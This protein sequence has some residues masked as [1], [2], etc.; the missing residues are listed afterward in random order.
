MP[1]KLIETARARRRLAVEKKRVKDEL[2]KLPALDPKAQAISH[3]LIGHAT[4]CDMDSHS[5]VLL[6]QTLRDFAGLEKRVRMVGQAKKFELWD[7]A[8]WNARR[9]ELL[10]QVEELKFEPSEALQSLIL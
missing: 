1:V 9:D 3:L 4:E 5:R 2:R 7:E 8:T 10:S 6:P